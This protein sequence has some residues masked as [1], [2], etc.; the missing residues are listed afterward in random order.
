MEQVRARVAKSAITAGRDPED[1]T[2]VAVTKNLPLDYVRIIHDLGVRDIGE[3]RAQEMS[4]KQQELP[5][6]DIR[7][8][9]VGHLQ[10]NKVKYVLGF[11]ELIHSL[12]SL[13][14]A[15][16]INGR[17]MAMGKTQSVLVEVNI[18]REPQK[19]GVSPEKVAE[20][21]EGLRFFQNISVVGLMTM[22]PQ[23]VRPVVAAKVFAGLRDIRDAQQKEFP[24][25]SWRWLSMGMSDDFEAAIQEGSNMVRLGRTLFQQMKRDIGGFE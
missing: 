14:L 22:A 1:I 18:S 15:R 13:S 5:A 7:W 17:A 12:D 24:E 8:H 2:L 25:L 3:N 4:D 10:R 9:M 6:E 16:E 11:V 21:V 19:H 23:D 20:L